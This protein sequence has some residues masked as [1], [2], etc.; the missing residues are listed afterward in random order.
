[1]RPGGELGEA[2]T[3]ARKNLGVRIVARCESQQQLVAVVARKQALRLELVA[4][5]RRLDMS[6]TAELA[7]L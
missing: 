6:E 7:A 5:R 1:M 2:A 3:I 4:R